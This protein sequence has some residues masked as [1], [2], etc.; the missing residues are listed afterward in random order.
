ME[1][2]NIKNTLK[3]LPWVN[4]G[5]TFEGNMYDK[6]LESAMLFKIFF[7][8]SCFFFFFFFLGTSLGY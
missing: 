5:N 8:F 2:K 4:W 7:L 6:S 3:K 1:F